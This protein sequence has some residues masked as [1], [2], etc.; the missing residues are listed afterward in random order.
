MLV[1]LSLHKCNMV[2]TLSGWMF[3]ICGRCISLKQFL[4]LSIKSLVSYFK[5]HLFD[6]I[7][8]IEGADLLE[9]LTYDRVFYVF[10]PSF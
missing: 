3:F 1:M 5:I 4:I 10:L 2:L 6:Y 7:I 8:A 9:V